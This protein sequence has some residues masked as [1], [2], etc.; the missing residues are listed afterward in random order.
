MSKKNEAL[1]KPGT[2]TAIQAALPD[3]LQEMKG[4]RLGQENVSQEDVLIP[5]LG[6][7]QSLSPQKKKNNEAFIENLE[8][9][10][11]FNT[12]SQEIYGRSITLIPIFFFKTF[13]HFKPIK[14]GGGIIAQY[15]TKADVPPELLEWKDGNPPV[16]TE[17][18]NQFCARVTE[19]GKLEPIVASFKSTGIKTAKKWQSYIN[20]LNAPSFVRQY[21][22]DV[23][24][25]V[26]GNQEWES[27]TVKPG[28]FVPP[29]IVAGLKSLFEQYAGSSVNFDVRDLGDEEEDAGQSSGM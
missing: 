21:V 24:H 11:L 7:C 2:S 23:C 12:V 17:F 29:E 10:D 15:P 18:K 27:L 4:Q 1:V 14:E 25:V 8:E 13:I 22:L 5:R 16:I 19:D 9:G 20:M 26:D 28:E 6:L 3:Y